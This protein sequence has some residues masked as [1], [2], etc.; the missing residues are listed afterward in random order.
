MLEQLGAVM[1]MEIHVPD[2]HKLADIAHILL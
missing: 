2:K 1:D